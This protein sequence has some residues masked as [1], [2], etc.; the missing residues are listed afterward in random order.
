MKFRY[1]ALLCAFCTSPAVAA[2]TILQAS[3]TVTDIRAIQNSLPT[4][5]P[6]GIISV[7]DIYNLTVSFDLANA[8]LS[9]VFDAD[10]TVNIYHLPGSVVT[11]NVGRY[12]TSYSPI[13]DFGSTLQLW[14]DRVIVDPVDAQSFSFFRYQAPQSELPFDMGLG[15]ISYTSSFFAFDN[16][17]QARSNDTISQIIPLDQFGSKSFSL[18][19][20]NPDTNLFVQVSGSVNDAQLINSAVP[21]PATWATMLLGFGLIGGAMRRRQKAQ[22]NFRNAARSAAYR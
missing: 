19:F 8:T 20:L 2:T 17:A 3:G 22:V 16:S 12:S 18:G 15:L 21:E 7:G 4:S 9:P 6:A 11:L 5:T 1:V 10:P 14:N 13:F